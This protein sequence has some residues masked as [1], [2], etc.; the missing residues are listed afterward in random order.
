MTWKGIPPLIILSEKVYEK[1]VSLSR[2][3]MKAIE[4][5]LSRNSILPKWDVLIRPV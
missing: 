4:A 5:R 3:A 1:G 2:K